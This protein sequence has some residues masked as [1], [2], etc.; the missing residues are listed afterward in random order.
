[1][2]ELDRQIF[3]TLNQNQELEASNDGMDIIVC[4][5]NIKTKTSGFCL[6]H[7][8]RNTCY[9]RRTAICQGKPFMQWEANRSAE[10]FYDDQEYHLRE[11]DMVYLFTD[12]YPDQFGG[13]GSKKMKISRLRTVIDEIKDPS[14]G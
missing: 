2:H 13:D 12:G 6:S 8:T 9:R 1:M 11:G 5:F 3:S 7:E 4:E 14:N 10:K